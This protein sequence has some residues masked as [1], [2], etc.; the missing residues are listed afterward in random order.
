MV[1][2]RL[3]RMGMRHRPTYRIV[4]MD[5]QRPRDGEYLESLGHY[6]P[7]TKRLALDLDRARYWVSVGAQPTGTAD[8]LIK[9][10]ARERSSVAD[11]AE[12]VPPEEAAEVAVELVTAEVVDSESTLAP[13][14]VTTEPPKDAAPENTDE[15]EKPDNN[16]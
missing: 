6:D 14:P 2:I 11:P 13:P 16:A 8:R 15:S 1:K 9:R 5:S 3:R 12:M 4:V 7:R 10:A